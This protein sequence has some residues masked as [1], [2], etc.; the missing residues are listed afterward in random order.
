MSRQSDVPALGPPSAGTYQV[1]D[2]I[3]GVLLL[4]RL[5]LMRDCIQLAGRNT[6]TLDNSIRKVTQEIMEATR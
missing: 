5:R 6:S 4:N 3:V 2:L 1:D